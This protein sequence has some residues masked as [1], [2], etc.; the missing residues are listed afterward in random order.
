[1]TRQT[2]QVCDSPLPQRGWLRSRF[3]PH[4]DECGWH[5]RFSDIGWP[6]RFVALIPGLA[7][8]ELIGG[9]RSLGLV[10]VAVV[11]GVFIHLFV[12]WE[13]KS[14]SR[15]IPTIFGPVNPF[16]A[17]LNKYYA[18]GT[19]QV[20]PRWPPEYEYL[21]SLPRPRQLRSTWQSVVAWWFSISILA[22][23]TWLIIRDARLWLPSALLPEW[24]TRSIIVLV[25]LVLIDGYVLAAN[26]RR[27]P[28]TRELLKK[29]EVGLAWVIFAKEVSSGEHSTM[30]IEYQFHD[31]S[32]RIHR[33]RCEDVTRN[34][35]EGAVVPVFYNPVRP[36][37]NIAIC[38]TDWEILGPD[39]KVPFREKPK[40]GDQVLRLSR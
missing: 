39:G 33:G 1:M 38:A 18:A 17:P 31:G 5:A 9:P 14:L 6:F 27:V 35:C 4:C 12:A 2:C 30:E 15:P 40:H 11:I 28:E 22:L 32:G 20:A 23:F 24:N 25:I 13:R 19:Q 21:L 26:L 3:A 8:M 34:F 16:S 29:G 7:L 36:S 37:Q 10:V